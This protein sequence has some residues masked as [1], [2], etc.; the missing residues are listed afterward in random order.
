GGMG[1]PSRVRRARSGRFSESPKDRAP[2][3]P[4]TQDQNGDLGRKSY[5]AQP[6]TP[7]SPVLGTVKPTVRRTGQG[8]G[9]AAA[10]HGIVCP[11]AY[12]KGPSNG[13]YESM[14]RRRYQKPSPRR[15]G[16]QWVLYYWADEFENGKG[17]RKKK[18]HVLGPANLGTR[19]VEQLRDE[20]L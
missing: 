4:G 6:R 13:D 18:R 3:K 9:R 12:P 17:K 16:Q 7:D 2:H 11:K 10:P 19:E 8:V 15:E 14:A 5:F 1:K 20:F